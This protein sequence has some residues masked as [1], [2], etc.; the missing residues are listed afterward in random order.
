[1]PSRTYVPRYYIRS[2]NDASDWYATTGTDTL[3]YNAVNYTFRPAGVW[4]Y[5]SNGELVWIEDTPEPKHIKEIL[6]E[7]DWEV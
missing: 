7:P 1:M 5:N 2:D 3:P 4:R 6:G